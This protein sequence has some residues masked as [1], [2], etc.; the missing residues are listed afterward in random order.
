[1]TAFSDWLTDLCTYTGSTGQ[2]G[3]GGSLRQRWCSITED[4]R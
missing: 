4:P 3:G 2:L 1:M